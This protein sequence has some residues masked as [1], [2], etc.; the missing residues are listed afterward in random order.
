[1][2]VGYCQ[3]NP[4]FG[5]IKKNI[6]IALDLVSSGFAKLVVLPELFNTGYLFVSRKETESLAEEIPDG[7]TSKKLINFA[8]KKGIYIVA[9]IAEKHGNEIYN[10][11]A[12]FGP[13][14]H[15]HTYRKLHL[16]NDEKD[17]FAPGDLPLQTVS[18]GNIKIGIMICF[19]W[20]FPET[21]R[22]L[23]LQGAD[24]ICH[25]A[26]LVLTLC[27]DSMKT[28]SIENRV[29]SIT[30]NRTGTEERSGKKLTYIGKSQ[31]VD[32]TGNIL[33]RSEP[34]ETCLFETEIDPEKSRN[35]S[36]L[37]K[38]NLFRDRR[39]GYYSEIS[40]IHQ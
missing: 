8:I 15:V 33:H 13:E 25:P 17:F 6:N 29:Y 28:R 35:K 14:G 30:A 1:M 20:I 9:G 24:I 2:R 19:D 36:I 7:H 26:N 40:N 10:S 16:F 27:P 11:A 4:E 23:S 5:E 34:E 32:P 3:F 18:A 38:N 21:A 22:I 37:E 39:A 31:I 12:L